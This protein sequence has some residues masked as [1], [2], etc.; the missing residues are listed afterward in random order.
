MII[1]LTLLSL[2]TAPIPIHIYDLFPDRVIYIQAD[3][4][5]IYLI[6]EEEVKKK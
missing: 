2:L 4:R 3:E 5:K 1:E 6:P